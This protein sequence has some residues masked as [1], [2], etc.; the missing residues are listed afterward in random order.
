MAEIA[1]DTDPIKK[2]VAQISKLSENLKEEVDAE[3]EEGARHFARLAK[4]D[5]PGDIGRLKGAINWVKRDNLS[6]EVFAG[7]NYAAYMEFGTKKKFK[8]I[9]GV[10][11]SVYQGK[12]TGDYYDFLNAILDWVRR[13]GIGMSTLSETNAVRRRFKQKT[14][15]KKDRLLDVAQAIANSIIR[16]GVKPHPFFYKQYEIVVPKMIAN[17]NNILNSVVK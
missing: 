9:S 12:G 13:K 1:I 8:A 3:L 4:E 10:D 5:A 16:H 14:V 11:S 7:T 6:Y 2:L 15:T 17:L